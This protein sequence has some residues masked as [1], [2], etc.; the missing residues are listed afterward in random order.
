MVNDIKTN[1]INKKP[2][3]LNSIFLHQIIEL[4]KHSSNYR[5][6]FRRNKRQTFFFLHFYVH[7]WVI[8]NGEVCN[9]YRGTFWSHKVYVS[10]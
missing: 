1:D 7:M 9:V 3:T 4:Q 6:S 2:V 8:F 5:L 10:M